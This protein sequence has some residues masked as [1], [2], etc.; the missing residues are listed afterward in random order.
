MVNV[1]LCIHVYTF[2]YIHKYLHIY[3]Y[4]HAYF[5]THHTTQ[6]SEAALQLENVIEL[7]WVGPRNLYLNI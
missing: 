5:A 4:T 2:V 6:M 1:M 3:K 7:V